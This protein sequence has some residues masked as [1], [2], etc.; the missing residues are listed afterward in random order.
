MAYMM[1]NKIKIFLEAIMDKKALS[2]DLDKTLSK[3]NNQF[4]QL[5]N[6]GYSEDVQCAINELGTITQEAL[7]GFK[8]AILSNLD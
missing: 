2:N 5:Q 4:E 6:R 7:N 3:F 8:K 1:Y